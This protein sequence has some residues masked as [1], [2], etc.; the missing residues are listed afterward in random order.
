MFASSVERF[1]LAAV[2]LATIAAVVVGSRTALAQQVE[3]SSEPVVTPPHL[4]TDSGATYPDAAL[5]E[6]FASTVT[7]VLILELDPTGIVR[8]ATVQTPQGHGF[9]EAAVEAAKS[10]VFEPALRDGKPVASKIKY[11]YVFA[12]PPPRLVGRV[13]TQATDHPLA[14][15]RVVVRDSHGDEH[16]TQTAVDG[17]WDVPNLPIGHVHISVTAPGK[18]P[19]EA[20]DQLNA[21]E[22]TGVTL[23]LAPE[24]V[25]ETA[26][27]DGGA[28]AEVAE[29]V[30]VKGERPPREV[31]KRTLGKEE[32]E[33]SPGTRGDALL[34]LQNLPGVAR[35]PVF[36][37]ALIVR[38][39][40]PQD[41]NV[42]IDGTT[43]P[44][45]YH[46][47]G[48]SSVIPSELLQKIDFYPGNFSAQYGRG[49]GGV[50]DVAI[51]DPKSDALH[52]M[53]QVDFIDARVLAEGPIFNTGWTFMIAGRRSYFD[54][55]L[56]P[57]LKS[58]GAGVS[59]APRYYD[60]Q[61][62]VQRDFNAH[63]SF[64]VMLFGSDDEL[65]ILN[66]TPSASS[67]TFGGD[68]G[69]H[70]SFWRVQARY[71][72]KISPQTELRLTAA[73]GQDSID[74]GFGT[75]ALDVTLNPLSTRA[76]ISEKLGRMVRLNV[77]LDVIYEPYSFSVELPPRTSPGQPSGGPGQVP[78]QSVQS[79]SLFLPG[80]YAD[81]EITP[82]R[83]A[84][85]LPGVR[86]DYDSATT[87]WD[88]APRISVRQDLTS[89][90]PR[91]TLK[92]GVGVYDQ[93]PQPQ[94]TAPN[95]GQAGLVSNRAIH[96]DV[97][98]EQEFT[99]QLDLSMDC[100]YKSFQN[101]VV[102]GSGNSGSG[103]AYGIEWLLRYK[104]D[105]HF[106]GWIS[107]TLSRSERRDA[108]GQP[109]YLFEYDQTHVLTV[110][111]SYKLGRGWQVG[112]RFRLVS[113]DL[114]T[115]TNEGAF[116]GT[117]GS[118]LGSNAYPPYGSRLPLF[119]QLDLRV[120]KAWT[121]QSWK[122]TFYADVQ[123]ITNTSNAEGV[124]YNYNYTQSST[125]SG[126]PILPS[127]GL[128]AEF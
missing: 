21:G 110:L 42:F 117:V 113:G 101:L 44:L 76:E 38:G 3:A 23:R 5:H 56:G 121:F 64:R 87:S 114:Y 118:Q 63:S 96:Y 37:G 59:T 29:E 57:V 33:H 108:S 54:L 39:S 103:Q 122:L 53:A 35:P 40:A 4:K 91:T 18:H 36:S 85:V 61:A 20:D 123:N 74:A 28:D 10:L 2:A 32:I 116:D 67:P 127:L 78:V 46:F 27:L 70:T 120:D 50:V 7:V 119:K 88:V 97:G 71:D 75:N 43:I 51:R 112:A 111:G 94:E 13:G 14:G 105:E 128:R 77:G 49:M 92:G 90:F 104:P 17:T 16:A 30:V 126:L 60:Y 83:G 102:A 80:A 22:E 79:G 82:W 26:S 69:F 52:G 41:T 124:T 95:I 115:P 93:P 68:V 86:A 45:V 6:H 65:Q 106:F 125:V 25:P 24:A 19:E 12:P 99:R 11:Q 47:G 66:Q 107:Y 48:L 109:L 34:S 15:A 89:G 72:N 55:W 58:A 73:F 31:T 98:A 81:L 9:D 84:R 1:R 62:I 8:N 100:W